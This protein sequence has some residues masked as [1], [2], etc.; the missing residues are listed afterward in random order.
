MGIKHRVSTKKFP[1]AEHR[2]VFLLQLAAVE[3]ISLLLE[4]FNCFYSVVYVENVCA[5]AGIIH[6]LR[7]EDPRKEIRVVAVMRVAYISALRNRSL[8]AFMLA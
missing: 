7:T 4:K 5:V 6:V 1:D 2:R 8:F 3:V